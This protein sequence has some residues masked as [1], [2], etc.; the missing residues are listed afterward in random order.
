MPWSKRSARAREHNRLAVIGVF[1]ERQDLARE[2]QLPGGEDNGGIAIVG[3]VDDEGACFVEVSSFQNP[4]IQIPIY[5]PVTL[6]HQTARLDL[7]FFDDDGCNSGALKLLKQRRHGRAVMKNHHVV[8]NTG[9]DWGNR[10][11]KRSSRYGMRYTGKTKKTINTPM[12][13]TSTT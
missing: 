2:S 13:C 12:N 7:V 4:F 10:V 6:F 11:S 1:H 5:D 8:F 3:A 9:V